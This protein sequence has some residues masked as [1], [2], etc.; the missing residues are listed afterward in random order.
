MNFVVLPKF[1]EI[2]RDMVGGVNPVLTT[3]QNY[4]LMVNVILA[5]VSVFAL[6]V[7]ISYVMGERLKVILNIGP[8]PLM[9]W[10]EYRLPW[11][12]K[13]MKR[14]FSTMLSILLD[15]G[16]SENESVKLAAESVSNQIFEHR[17]QMVARHL[18]AGEKLSDAIRYIDNA[19]EFRWRLK[20]ATH[21][22]EGFHS[23]LRGWHEYLDAKAYQ[24]EQASSQMITTSFVLLNGL[25]VGVFAGGMFYTLI[26]IVNAVLD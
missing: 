8:V 11:R 17:A 6:L 9:D 21:V 5:V 7:F 19:G 22:K 13:R 10:I 14:D 15:A 20:N 12:S 24:Q 23:A 3:L 26:M 4:G 16:L 25:V 1:A 2:S 18:E